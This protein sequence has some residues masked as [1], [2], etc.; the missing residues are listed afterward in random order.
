[1]PAVILDVGPRR[2]DHECLLVAVD[3]V[4]EQAAQRAQQP[5]ASHVALHLGTNG[6]DIVDVRDAAGVG[7]IT[8]QRLASRHSSAMPG[9][10][11]HR[12]PA[13]TADRLD[14]IGCVRAR[15]QGEVRLHRPRQ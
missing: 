8:A 3:I 14:C 13:P 2:L 11:P 9:A 6:M 12:D 1:M 10:D 7:G 4:A 5:G 15:A